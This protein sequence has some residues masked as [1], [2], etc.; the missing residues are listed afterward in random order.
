MSETDNKFK[1]RIIGALVLVGLAII[2][3]PMLFRQ[4]EEPEPQPPVRVD[5]PSMPQLA[6]APRYEVQEVEV[7]QPVQ[8]PEAL[9]EQSDG[10]TGLI[11]PPVAPVVEETYTLIEP[12][13]MPQPEPVIQVQPV[14]E[15]VSPAVA[16]EPK[17]Q[18]KPEPAVRP[19]PKPESPK[20]AP[21]VQ[22]PVVSAPSQP[23]SPGLDNN[24]LPLSW[25]IQ[26]GSL[27]NLSN[28]EK[29]RDSYRARHYT[30][31]V[32]SAG[33]VHKVFIGPL[34]R[35]AEAQAMCKQL[36]TRDG[37]DCFVVRYQP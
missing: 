17:T 8:L 6:P 24:N 35:E 15:P 25:A 5:A 16:V 12:A 1:Q 31:Y 7:P 4:E 28:A 3:L 2:F 19:E 26:L 23:V 37:Q 30:A 20:P 29:L 34:I 21:Q 11:E 36:K 27:G 14:P 9:P 33:G 22:Q 13:A 32:R 18:P 10:Y